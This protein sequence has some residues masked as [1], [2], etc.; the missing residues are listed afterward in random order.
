MNVESADSLLLKAVI[1]SIEAGKAIMEVYALNNLGIT[2]TRWISLASQ[3][4]S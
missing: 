2:I 3:D 1:A 4:I